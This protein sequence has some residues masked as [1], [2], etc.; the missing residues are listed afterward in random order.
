MHTSMQMDAL[1]GCKNMRKKT[2]W[3][4]SECSVKLREHEVRSNFMVSRQHK[5]SRKAK[6]KGQLCGT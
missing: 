1:E 2:E 5:R 4:D 6:Q 3:A